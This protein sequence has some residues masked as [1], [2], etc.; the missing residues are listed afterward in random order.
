MMN[1][2]LH[3]MWE[4]SRNPHV[5][6]FLL[7]AIEFLSLLGLASLI[8]DTGFSQ[9]VQKYRYVVWIGSAL[10]ASGTAIFWLYN[11]RMGWTKYH[12]AVLTLRERILEKPELGGIRPQLV[13]GVNQGGAILGGLLYYLC[14]RSFHFATVWMYDEWEIHA[15]EAQKK[16]LIRI[17]ETLATSLSGQPRILLVDDSSK[18]GTAL[19]KARDLVTEAIE[20][21]KMREREPLVKTAVIVFRPDLRDE[22]KGPPP[23]YFVSQRHTHFPYAKV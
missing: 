2:S 19:G 7:M 5:Q 17:L 3:Q 9:E 1:E 4:K 23:D 10:I 11:R 22:T 13:I 21:T 20:S 14:Y 6:A 15:R 12:S 8:S 16:E 18:T